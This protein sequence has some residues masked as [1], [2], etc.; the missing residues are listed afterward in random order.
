MFW[1]KALIPLEESW[2]VKW[3]YGRGKRGGRL[4][5]SSFECCFM[6]ISD[7]TARAQGT[8]QKL[9]QHMDLVA[10]IF[11]DVQCCIYA[12]I[13]G[14]GQVSPKNVLTWYMDGPQHHVGQNHC[15]LLE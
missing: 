9:R 11:A 7:L 10:I 6:N 8:I 13:V 1:L 3:P 4:I 2:I 5:H 12:D 14:T 15:P